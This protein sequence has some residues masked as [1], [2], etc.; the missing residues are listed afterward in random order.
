MDRNS[1]AMV[2]KRSIGIKKGPTF[3][4]SFYKSLDIITLR[5]AVQVCSSVRFKALHASV[6]L[7]Y[8]CDRMLNRLKL[9]SSKAF[10]ISPTS[11]TRIHNPKVRPP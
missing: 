1:T 7:F 8:A 3:V 2:K 9:A 4:T 6:G 11:H 5:S 10:N